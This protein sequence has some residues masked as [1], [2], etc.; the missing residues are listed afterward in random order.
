MASDITLQLDE[1]SSSTAFA[2]DRGAWHTNLPLEVLKPGCLLR[3]PGENELLL[4]HGPGV[5]GSIKLFIQ[6]LNLQGEFCHF[7]IELVEAGVLL[8]HPPVIKI[9]DLA[10]QMDEVTTGFK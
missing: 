10:L 8:S 4:R 2:S 6:D 3:C 9:F 5:V 1:M 7:I